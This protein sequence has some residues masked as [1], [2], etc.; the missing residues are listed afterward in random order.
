MKLRQKRE[1]RKMTGSKKK[2]NGNEEHGKWREQRDLFQQ[3]L[4]KPCMVS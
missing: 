2:E 3:L 1:A 4:H